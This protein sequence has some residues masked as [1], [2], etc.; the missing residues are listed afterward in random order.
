MSVG[1]VVIVVGISIQHECRRGSLI[2]QIYRMMFVIGMMIIMG[3]REHAAHFV[4]MNHDVA[5][6]GHK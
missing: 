4:A 1:A 3:V 5:P 6:H 2:V